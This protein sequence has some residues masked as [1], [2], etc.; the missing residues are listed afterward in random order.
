MSATSPAV[1]AEQSRRALLTALA[2]WGHLRC[3]D[4]A[5]VVWPS[6]RYAE[7]MC[8]RHLC[9]M[10]KSGEIL[11]RINSVGTRS[12]VLTRR[13]AAMADAIGIEA[14]HGLD[15]SSVSGAT[16]IHRS[17]ATRFG[18]ERQLQGA[19]VFGEH[20]LSSGRCPINRETLARRFGKL[21]DLLVVERGAV[22]ADW[23]E[24]ECA[25]KPKATIQE[26]LQMTRHW[27]RE[28]T[29]SDP[30]LQFGRLVFVCDGRYNHAS[31]IR[32]AARE[33]WSGLGPTER[34]AHASRVS[35]VTVCLGATARWMSMSPPEL[36]SL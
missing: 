35:I 7:Q 17:I 5:R 14:R 24:V 36:L 25:A 13:G 10:L 4:L 18:I 31:R 33:F 2:Q 30:H 27:G 16:F 34:M 28:L 22:A 21:P 6:A 9:R 8:Q 15:L 29:D 11:C 32:K 1:R 12:F 20:A 23:V 26:A 19:R 3:A